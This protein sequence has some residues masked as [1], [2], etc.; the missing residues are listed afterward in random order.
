MAGLGELADEIEGVAAHRAIGAEADAQAVIEH[1]QR[2]RDALGGLDVGDHVVRDAGVAGLE[3]RDV[4]IG[5]EDAV[6]GDE[7][8]IKQADGVEKLD[9]RHVVILAQQRHLLGH[10]GEM[11]E[12]RHIEVGG[13]FRHE[14]QVRDVDRVGRVR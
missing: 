5:D 10:L 6:R 8:T 14:L 2:G 12:H 4:G 13:E 1:L 11:D 7:A 3:Q 9:G